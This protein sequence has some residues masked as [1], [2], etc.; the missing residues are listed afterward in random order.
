M[1]PSLTLALDGATLRLCGPLVASGAAEPARATAGRLTAAGVAGA[2]AD[3]APRGAPVAIPE[4]ATLQ[5]WLSADGAGAPPALRHADPVVLADLRAEAGGVTHG[6]VAVGSHVGRTRFEVVRAGERLGALDIDIVPTKAT[7]ADVAAMRA[8]VEAAWAGVSL[9]A[10]RPSTVTLASAAEAPR[11]EAV[12]LAL[13][14]R[15]LAELPAALRDLARRPALE[16][17]RAPE[18]RRTAALGRVRPSEAAALAR[19]HGADAARWPARVRATDADET[20]DTPALRWIA[21]RLGQAGA[22]LRDLDRLAR[23]RQSARAQALSDRFGQAAGA[24]GTLRAEPPLDTADGVA[25][26]VPPLAL[27][28]RPALR[29]VYDALRALDRGLD[30]AEGDLRLAVRDLATLYETWATLAVVRATARALGAEAPRLAVRRSGVDVTLQPG[31]LTF[32]GPVRGHLAVQPRYGGA[33][34]LLVQ[35]PD[36]VLTLRGPGGTRRLA[37]DAKYRRDDSPRAL[38]RFGSP[39]PPADALGAL[40]RYRDAVLG[41]DGQRGWLDAAVALFPY[42]P[43]RGAPASRLVEAVAELG[44]GALP[45]LPGETGALDAELA[46]AVSEVA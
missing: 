31:E 17:R 28:R 2:E 41:P 42:R 1:D 6:R 44:V 19:R 18:L 15:A 8:E 13:L 12:W 36:L 3:G 16:V 35:R 45:L 27:R 9:A 7:A 11:P 37:L 39:A 46:R 14:D 29:R 23:E 5:V 21:T 22:R 30:L 24:L 38:R 43:P 34:A 40:H 26:R 20:A 10:L 4:E 25:P 33:P 32:D